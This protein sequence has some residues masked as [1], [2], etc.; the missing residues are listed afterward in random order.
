MTVRENT[1]RGGDELGVGIN[2]GPGSPTIEGNDIGDVEVGQ[3]VAVAAGRMRRTQRRSC[4][5]EPG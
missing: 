4:T 5:T 2:L 1:I 3:T